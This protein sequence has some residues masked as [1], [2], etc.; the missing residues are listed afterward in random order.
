MSKKLSEQMKRRTSNNSKKETSELE[1]NTELMIS[2]GS[3]LLDL[4]ISGLRI[5]GG[6]LP[7]G[8]L[9]EI[10]GPSGAGKTVMLQEIG[11][12]IQSKGG[13][14]IFNDPEARLDPNFARKFDL[15]VDNMVY[16]T[17]DTVP[18]LFKSIYNWE[19]DTSII[20][21][22][23]ADSLA[24]LSTDMEMEKD[25]GD[26]MGG[27]RAKEFSEQLRKVARI[28]KKNNYLMVCSNQ[29]RETMNTM[30][31]AEKYT[32]PGGKA[33]GFYSSVR[34]Q[35]TPVKK[36]MK[37]ITF[38]GKKI[39]QQT[40]VQSEVYVYKN[41]VSEP[42]KRAI[43][44]INFQYGIDDIRENLQFVKDYSNENVYTLNDK[45]LDR[46]LDKSCE[47]IEQENLESELREQVIDLW[48]AIQEK[49]KES[50]KPKKRF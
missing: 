22:I 9:V 43:L 38:R 44:T 3:T 1:G 7:A 13:M 24:A 33:I 42:G 5:R 2:T 10:F 47:I 19:A 11:G 15:D 48:L 21:G 45:K 29:I 31:F 20:N 39:K 17:P 36:I 6:G 34:L 32:A 46:G 26:K 23:M 27:R 40:G 12:I 50:R 18:E 30:P 14:L 25:E 28:I 35:I 8:I 49:Y 41:S 37:E 16:H 4:A